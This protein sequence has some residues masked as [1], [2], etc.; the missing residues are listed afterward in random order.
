MGMIY[1]IGADIVEVTR[2][3]RCLNH[4]GDRFR[5]RIF[6][7]EEIA[8]CESL[9]HPAK[10]RSYAARFAAKEALAKASRLGIGPAF[11]WVDLEIVR[12]ARGAPSVVLHGRAAIWAD[13]ES[14]GA[15]HISLSHSGAHALA[16]AIIEGAAT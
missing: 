14:V 6:A 9:A 8:Y 1:G 13:R 12:Q 7:S 16:Y 3:E 5:D 4:H 10:Y 2:I 15:I 11:D